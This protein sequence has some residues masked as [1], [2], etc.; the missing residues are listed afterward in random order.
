MLSALNTELIIQIL[1][2]LPPNEILSARL[3]SHNF[4]ST[5]Q[6]SVLLRYLVE[7]FAA[8]VED[9]PYCTLSTA[10]RL[11][12]LR[13]RENAWMALSP[14]FLAEY[15]TP[16]G[17]QDTIEPGRLIGNIYAQ[18]GKQYATEDHPNFL[19]YMHLPTSPDDRPQWKRI[20]MRPQI[21][22]FDISPADDLIAIATW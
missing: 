2:L 19:D 3:L 7:A 18:S 10:D 12:A 6:E 21:R 15:A 13:K 11:A 20:Q 1:Q 8:G 4:N 14:T 5:I 17:H 22:S 9:N 16:N